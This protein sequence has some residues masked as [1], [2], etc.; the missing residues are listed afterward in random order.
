MK[1]IVSEQNER[2]LHICAFCKYWFDPTCSAL[3]PKFGMRWEVADIKKTCRKRMFETR[4]IH[5]C[6]DYVRKNNI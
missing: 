4:S 3:K 5:S 2:S 6:M 1:K